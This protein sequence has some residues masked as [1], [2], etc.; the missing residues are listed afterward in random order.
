MSDSSNQTKTSE[1]RA[2]IGT[3]VKDL[4][5]S[6]HMSRTQLSQASGV[7]VSRIGQIERGE[8]Y[9]AEQ[10]MTELATVLE[11]EPAAIWSRARDIHEERIQLQTL[12]T[13]LGIPRDNW[14]EFF[15]LGE[16][17]RMEIVRAIQA[18]LPIRED[19][20]SHLDMVEQAIDQN[21]VADNLPLILS[22]IADYG[23]GPVDSMRASVELEEMPDDRR[24]FTERLPL[25]PLRVTVDWLYLFR[26]TYG[27]DPPSPALL[28]WWAESRRTAMDA[29]LKVHQSRTIVP[30]RLINEYLSRGTRGQSIVLSPDVVTKHVVEVIRMLR[31]QPHFQLGLSESELPMTYRIKGNHHVLVTVRRSPV[32][33]E[34][35]RQGTTL[36]FARPS[37]V[38]RFSEHFERE[39]DKITAE[40]K[41]RES[42]ARWLEQRLPGMDKRKQR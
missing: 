12:L 30:V 5:T 8:A 1:Y 40:F 3:V 22:A 14:D 20:R 42:V 29:T 19:R 24:V 41:D 37:V 13:E 17:A 2:S 36:R 18:R 34:S 33:A 31:N 23:L 26:A 28:R 15:R 7:S 6:R 38:K 9:P 25:S 10:L 27:T 32:D 21:G 4:R 11:V 16:T 35:I 39:W